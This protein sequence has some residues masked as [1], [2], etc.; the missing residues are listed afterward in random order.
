MLIARAGVLC[1]LGLDYSAPIALAR[2][3]ARLAERRG[4]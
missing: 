4:A 1:V 3:F 2:E